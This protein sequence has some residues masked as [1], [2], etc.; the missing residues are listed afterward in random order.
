M[1]IQRDDDDDEND[2]DG[3][4]GD[5]KTSGGGRDENVVF[6]VKNY[7]GGEI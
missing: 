1:H 4:S 5:Q 3:C 6:H 2:N 7:I